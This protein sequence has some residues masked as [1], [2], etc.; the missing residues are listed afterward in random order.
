[1][2]YKNIYKRLQALFTFGLPTPSP[3]PK[4][5]SGVVLEGL[6]GHL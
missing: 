6:K 2:F 3:T 5:V 4:G 1:M